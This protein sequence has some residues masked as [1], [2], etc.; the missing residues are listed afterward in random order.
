MNRIMIAGSAGAGK[1]TLSRQLG[2]ALQLPVVHL[3][4]LYWN[5]GWVASGDEE[6]QRRVEAYVALDQWI[7]DG[8]YNKT[9][10][11]RLERAD[12][13]IFLDMPR[14]LCL[15]RVLKRR[16]QYHGRSRPDLT[17]GC[18]EQIDWAFL[19]WIWDYPKRSRLKIIQA[20]EAQQ[21]VKNIIFLK[22]RKAVKA[23][24]QDIA[25]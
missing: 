6:M 16:I 22:G 18:P 4:T 2:E 14:P 3:D 19:K 20:M 24:L 21:G 25:R 10:P 7:I 23:F 1:S 5:P 11:M 17:E 8:N 13:I 15:Y 9:F 12:T